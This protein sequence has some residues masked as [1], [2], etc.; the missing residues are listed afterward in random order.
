MS[1]IGTLA[2]V[3]RATFEF[4]NVTLTVTDASIGQ[5]PR[6]VVWTHRGTT[7]YRYRSSHREYAIPVLLVFAL[8]N[9]PEIFDL[10]PGSS[11]VEF[12]LAEGFDVFLVDW[13]VPDEED[14]E[15]GLAEF[16]CDELH[17]A[18]RE[19]LRAAGEE[20]LTL[21][22]WC[23]GGTLSAMYCALHPS[24][25]VRN[26]VLL[27][28][29][30]DPSGSLYARWVGHDEFDVDLI[31]D[32][33]RAVPGAA[34]DWANKLMK[35]VTNHMT[36]YR[37]LFQKILDGKDPRLSYQAMAKW[38]ADNP[39]FPSRAYREWITWMYKENRLLDGRLR[40]RGERVDLTRIEQNLLVVTADADHI[41]PPEGT[42]PLLDLV[43]SEDV[44]HLDRQG[45]HIGLMA[46]SKAKHEIWPELAHWMRERSDR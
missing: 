30:I 41:A 27:T 14:S 33:Y 4:V 7:L 20:E 35:P 11:F 28:T 32:S 29:P 23:I 16:V 3:P 10:R 19:T 46:G 6:E 21:L 9:R 8:I 42:V 34:I 44:T 15:M 17:W 26:A 36:T 5:T 1:T 13:G 38:V 39:P 25:P 22:G 31:A 40:L 2:R 45:G 12:L 24:G 43:S 37:L 18:V